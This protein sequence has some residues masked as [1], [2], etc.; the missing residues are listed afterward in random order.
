MESN[1]VSYPRGVPV[2]FEVGRGATLK[3]V[4]GNTYIDF[5]GG[6]GVMNIGHH[7]PRVVSAIKSQLDELAHN[8]D[9]PNPTR[10]ALAAA[11]HEIAPG[12]LRGHC[13]VLFC[14][15][16]GSDAIEASLKIA[17]LKSGGRTV[18]AFEG[19]YHGMT[20]GALAV[21]SSRDMKGRFVPLVADTHFVPF[22]YCYRCPFKEDSDRGKCCRR[23]EAQ[24]ATTLDDPH[25]GLASPA[26]IIV[27]PVQGEGGSIVPPDD[28]LKSV[29]RLADKHNVPLIFDE[30]QC[31][32]G[33]TG[34][35][36]A[37]ENFGVSPDIMA[38]SKGI[39]GGL[40]LAAAVYDETLD[41]AT[42]GAHYGTFRGNLLAMAAGL[43]VLEF[44]EETDLLAHVR[45][46][47]S[48]L[49]QRLGELS[50]NP[51]VGEVRGKGLMIGVEYVKDKE[52]KAPAPEL[53]SLVRRSCLNKGLV[54]ELGGH[55]HN[56]VR[57]L[58]PLVITMEL[59]DKGADIFLQVN[60]SLRAKA[61]RRKASKLSSP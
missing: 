5:F 42:R 16:T 17:K 21:S 43:A 2:A 38:I 31:G 4:D 10:R 23:A 24:L 6:A 55:Y 3:D 30:I 8:L 26:T 60:E 41:A 39:G 40:P 49:T 19:S 59:A 28:F 61:R 35:M 20:S 29:R 33:R 45:R 22:P 1:A 52:T 57:F 32:M 11:I 18:I 9:F 47:G 51:F 44:Y 46:V 48:R 34:R 25:S 54:V 58:P 36:F 14:G 53:A 50:E 27:E 12:H 37:C 56:V 7:N 15:P 13:K